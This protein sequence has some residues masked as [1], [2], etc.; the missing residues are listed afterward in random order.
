[1]R[2]RLHILLLAVSLIFAVG[3]TATFALSVGDEPEVKIVNA[4][5]VYYPATV[6]KGDKFSKPAVLVS[7]TVFDSIDEWKEI[8]RRKLTKGDAEYHLL[9]KAAND[10]FNC[11]LKKVRQ[12]SS[13]DI[14]AETGA[15]DCRNCDA[16]EITQAVI[17]QLPS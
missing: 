14:V 16:A 6:K 15:I 3:A 12:A 8:K 17:D 4:S 9:L 2:Q 1:M 5:Q 11:A 13:Y 10:K 7:M